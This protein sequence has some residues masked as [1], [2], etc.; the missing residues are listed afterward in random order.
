[1]KKAY[2]HKQRYTEDELEY[3]R[4]NYAELPLSV[5]A[6]ELGRSP[7]AVDSKIRRL[8]LRGGSREKLKHILKLRAKQHNCASW[9][10]YMQLRCR[11]NAGFAWPG[12]RT[13]VE[14]AIC[15]CLS[16]CGLATAREIAV[17][18]GLTLR[19]VRG[20]V[21]ALKR[22]EMLQL[23]RDGVRY[24]YR[25][26]RRSGAYHTSHGAERSYH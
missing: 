6:A 17:K 2:H 25:L 19:T 1:M 23:E 4:E 20:N 3:L 10:H 5:L 14:V 9:G 18:T 26:A 15:R 13:K 21:T 12:C 16:E 7:V 24:A 22:A 11:V 8:K